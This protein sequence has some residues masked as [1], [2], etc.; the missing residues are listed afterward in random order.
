[1]VISLR[2]GFTQ[3]WLSDDDREIYDIFIHGGCIKKQSKSPMVLLK[4]T[5][6]AIPK[7]RGHN[8]SPHKP[9]LCISACTEQLLEVREV[10]AQGIYRAWKQSGGFLG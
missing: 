3:I 6:N 2:N 10:L 8:A 4:A 5:H 9:S 1:L 7:L